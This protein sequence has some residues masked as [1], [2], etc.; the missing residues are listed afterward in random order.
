MTEKFRRAV[1]V[2][3]QVAEKLRKMIE[4]KKP[5]E[6]VRNRRNEKH[7]MGEV[8]KNED[9]KDAMAILGLGAAKWSAW[10]AAG[11]AQFL[12]TLARWMTL[13]NQFIRQMENKF[14]VMNVGKGKNGKSK[15]SSVLSQFAKKYPSTT[16]HILWLMGLGAVAG[17]AYVATE[18][19]PDKIQEYKEWRTDRDAERVAQESARGTYR[20]FLNKMRPI[21]PFLIADLIVKEG[22]HVN[23]DG[24]HVPYRDSRG[25]PTIG[26]GSTVMK[27]GSRVTMDTP[28]MTTEEAYELARWHLEEGETYFVLYCY[29]VAMDG[30]D[31]NTTSEALGLSSIVYNSYSKLIE[32]PSDKNNRDRF[33][34]LRQLLDT[35]GFAVPDTAVQRVFAKYPVRDLTSFG[36]EWVNQSG[37]NKMADKLGGFLAGGRGLFWRRW[38]EAGL[39]TGK[40]TPQMLLECPINGMYEFFR[41][42]GEQKGAFFTGDIDHRRVNMQTFDKFK[43]WLAHPVNVKGQDLSHWKKVSDYLPGDVLAYCQVGK[44]ELSNTDFDK[45][46]KP[47]QQ[48]VVKTYT[49]G[50]DEQYKN[51]I[52]AYV[53]KDWGQAKKQFEQ[54]VAQYPDNALLRNDL[55]ATYNK[56]GMYKQAVE[57]AREILYR[58]CDKSQYAAAQYNAGYAY[59]KMG[60]YERALANYKLSVVNGNSRVASDVKR[61]QRKIKTGKTIAFHDA[62]KNMN[63][64]DETNDGLSNVFVNSSEHSA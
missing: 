17:G 63:S 8:D 35:H 14:A 57:Q 49:I 5:A 37:V 1:A 32:N 29:D 26:F 62:V 16:A 41:I 22:V 12:L 7:A 20:A 56:L 58:I 33:A 34:E 30:I 44:C 45:A 31:I 39:L 59:E 13:D 51:A 60:D 52:S 53:A 54:M 40:I 27:D 9:F 61:V 4:S 15:N 55:A 36:T 24:L 38:L 50:Y 19:A 48:V 25:I 43:Q 64:G 21:T 23:D 11:G 46:I 10:L 3:E 18:Y 2:P 28:P 42:M 47:R 6:Y